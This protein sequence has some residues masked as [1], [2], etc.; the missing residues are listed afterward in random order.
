MTTNRMS[1]MMLT[2]T[3]FVS[4]IASYFHLIPSPPSVTEMV[5]KNLV[6]FDEIP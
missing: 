4:R 6:D 1:E 3:V 2:I 5:M